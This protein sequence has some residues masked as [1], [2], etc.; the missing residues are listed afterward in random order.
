M[1]FVIALFLACSLT[2]SV[3]VVRGQVSVTIGCDQNY[4]DDELLDKLSGI[5]LATGSVG[6]DKVVYSITAKWV[7][8]HQFMEME[9]TDTARKAA[10]AAKVF[11]GYDCTA[12]K[13]VAHWI[14]NFGGKFS[15][16]LGYGIKEGNAITL[17]FAYPEG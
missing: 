16:T 13:Y 15:E 10:Y 1:K 2:C 9:L 12:H 7:L 6:G 3:Q 14:D 17:H 5:W 8:N 11:I 4:F